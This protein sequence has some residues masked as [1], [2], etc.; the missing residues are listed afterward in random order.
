LV[1]PALE[2]IHQVLELLTS[3]SQ[4]IAICFDILG[5]VFVVLPRELEGFF[6]FVD[7]SREVE[8]QHAQLRSPEF[9][10]QKV[11]KSSRLLELNQRVPEYLT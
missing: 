4:D 6:K 1:D 9:V 10:L 5:A 11:G 8:F 7:L 2:E 3:S